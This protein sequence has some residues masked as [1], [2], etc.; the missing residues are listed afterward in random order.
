MIKTLNKKEMDKRLEQT[1][2]IKLPRGQV[3]QWSKE[4]LR[5]FT[6]DVSEKELNF[7]SSIVRVELVGLYLAFQKENELRL[8]F[9]SL[10]LAK[11]AT[12]NIFELTEEQ[13]KQWISGQE[14]ELDTSNLKNIDNEYILIRYKQDIVGCGKLA[15]GKILNFIPKERRLRY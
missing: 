10:F 14:I 15:Q 3:I 5:V 2:G 9:D 4:K 11:D 12:K 6:G 8:S 1:Y 7:L 13:F